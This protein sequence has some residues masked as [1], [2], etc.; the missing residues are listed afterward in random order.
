MTHR[1]ERSADLDMT[2]RYA[3][4]SV[5]IAGAGE[6]PVIRYVVHPAGAHPGPIR[7]DMIA[8][9]LVTPR[10]SRW[11]GVEDAYIN[12]QLRMV[13]VGTNRRDEIRMKWPIVP[14]KYRR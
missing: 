7:Q 1:Y 4:K 13:V 2:P 9:E 5:L 14:K 8:L 10:G 3:P 6:V 11:Y 12:S